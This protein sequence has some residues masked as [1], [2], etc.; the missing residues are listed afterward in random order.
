VWREFWADR[1]LVR[2]GN[3]SHELG[4]QGPTFSAGTWRAA[5]RAAEL[6]RMLA[7]L[8]QKFILINWGTQQVLSGCTDDASTDLFVCKKNDTPAEIS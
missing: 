1:L 5:G 2:G 4:G 8:K 6:Q 3:L 7:Q